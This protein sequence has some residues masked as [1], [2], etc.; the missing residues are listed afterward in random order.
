MIP[1]GRN[2]PAS[3]VVVFQNVKL[4]P[5]PRGAPPD[6]MSLA[7][8]PSMAERPLLSVLP[9]ADEETS[10][11]RERLAARERLDGRIIVVKTTCL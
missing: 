5:N 10:V 1:P 11:A 2:A 9:P 8:E 6:P 3:P 4:A 7:S